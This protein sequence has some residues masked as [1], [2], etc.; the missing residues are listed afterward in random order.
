SRPRSPRTS[1]RARRTAGTLRGAAA[2]RAPRRRPPRP[3]THRCGA[4]RR[5][6]RAVQHPSGLA[7][8]SPVLPRRVPRRGSAVL[9]ALPATTVH[10]ATRSSGGARSPGHVS[11]PPRV[12]L[13]R[14]A[15]VLGE[16]RLD[17][18]VHGG[19]PLVR[20]VHLAEAP[21][22]PVVAVVAPAGDVLA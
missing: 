12:G 19:E 6:P 2:R 1:R 22:D 20:H 14:R 17:V 13:D 18:L 7:A 5:A 16:S 11:R 10:G 9:A 4:E 15:D 3:A 8:S 21:V